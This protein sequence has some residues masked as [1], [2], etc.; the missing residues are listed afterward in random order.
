VPIPDI[1]S[2]IINHDVGD[3]LDQIKRWALVAEL[4]NSVHPEYINNYAILTTKKDKFSDK[5]D[6]YRLLLESQTDSVQ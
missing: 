1:Q 3:D 6:Q 2:A 5:L 4:Y